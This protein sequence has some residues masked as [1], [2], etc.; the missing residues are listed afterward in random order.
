[1]LLLQPLPGAYADADGCRYSP[2]H[3]CLFVNL[4]STALFSLMFTGIS[5][6]L[7]STVDV[8]HCLA[9]RDYLWTKL[10]SVGSDSLD[11]RQLSTGLSAV[12]LLVAPWPVERVQGLCFLP[13]VGLARFL[14]WLC[15][16]TNLL[17]IDL[18]SWGDEMR[19]VRLLATAINC[20]IALWFIS[21]C[22]IFLH[23]SCRSPAPLSAPEL[24]PQSPPSQW[25]H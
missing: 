10:C 1:M 18:V 14:T 3:C 11:F 5:T 23:R 4:L 19:P 16:L 12:F 21:T 20:L 8:Y 25:F 13:A 22:S 6:F 17:T 7:W 15:V 24:S 9:S 2:V